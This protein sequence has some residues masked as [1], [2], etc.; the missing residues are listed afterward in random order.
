MMTT[1]SCCVILV[2]WCITFRERD[3]DHIPVSRTG[4]I[5]PKASAIVRTVC[6]G[7]PSDGV[8][9]PRQLHCT[10]AQGGPTVEIPKGVSS[11]TPSLSNHRGEI[12]GSDNA[13][14]YCFRFGS[15]RNTFN[16]FEWIVKLFGRVSEP[17]M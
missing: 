9:P 12:G 15:A 1:Y 5:E 11:S 13:V 17:H 14:P 7:I 3:A 16:R 8:T 10:V 2:A 6:I 4:C